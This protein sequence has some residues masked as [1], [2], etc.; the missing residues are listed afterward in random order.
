[1]KEN[2]RRRVI[3]ADRDGFYLQRLKRSLERKGDMA[4]MGMTDSGPAVLE[5][6]KKVKPDVILMDI[7]LGER[8]GFW[9]L[10]NLKKEGIDSREIYPDSAD[11]KNREHREIA[12]N[13]NEEPYKEKL[14]KL[15]MMFCRTVS[16]NLSIAYDKDSPVFRGATFMGDEAVREGLADGYNTLEGAARW[17]LAQS[18][19]NKTNQ[20]F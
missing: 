18:V 12:E 4:V 11:L 6:A 15:H 16:E 1:M 7:L 9:V 13:N 20:I 14:S 3:L 5:M 8:D 10:E 19:I 17:I 2:E